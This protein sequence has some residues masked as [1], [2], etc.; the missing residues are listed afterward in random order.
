MGD[1]KY[2]TWR[3]ITADEVK[4]NLGFSILIVQ[5]PSLDDYWKRDPLLDYA[6]IADR[7][8]RDR[9]RD[10]S[11]YLHFVDNST[12]L[13]RDSPEYDRLGKVRPLID[14]FRMKFAE[15][16]NPHKEVAVDEAM[17]KFQG[18]SSLK[19]LMPLKPI[20]R[21]I[22]VWVLG[23]SSN[24]YFSKFEVYTGKEASA[25]KGLGTRVVK[26]LTSELKGKNHHVSSTTFS[27]TMTFLPTW[28]RMGFT[29]AEQRRTG[30]DSLRN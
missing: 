26:E 30:G 21:G 29:A 1:E 24:G 11:R 13:P 28:R 8:S 7:I 15:L 10:I 3:V 9:F 23:D 27:P 2:D 18:R 17:I 4:A 20:K 25:E 19:Q 16:Y 14:Y 12:L 5:L 6:P 22:R